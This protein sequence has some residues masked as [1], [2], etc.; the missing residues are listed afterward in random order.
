MLAQRALFVDTAVSSGSWLMSISILWP[1]KQVKD[2]LNLRTLAY[3]QSFHFVVKNYK[4]P[5]EIKSLS[6]ANT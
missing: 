5:M 6:L 4:Q 1:V 3:T 2:R